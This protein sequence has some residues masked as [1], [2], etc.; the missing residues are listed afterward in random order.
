[1]DRDRDNGQAEQNEID[2]LATV[3]TFRANGFKGLA[4][5]VVCK[6]AVTSKLEQMQ[7]AKP[8]TSVELDYLFPGGWL[9]NHPQHRWTIDGTGFAKRPKKNMQ[10]TERSR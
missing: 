3:A 8:V 7:Q 4:E 5:C 1:M 9:P 2:R 6:A 10:F